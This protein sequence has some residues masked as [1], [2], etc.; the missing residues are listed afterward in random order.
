L[1]ACLVAMAAILVAVPP[2]AGAPRSRVQAAASAIL[3]IGSADVAQGAS[4]TVPLAAALDVYVLA[5]VTVDVQYD[6]GVVT[7]TACSADPEDLFDFSYCNVAYASDTVRFV[8]ISAQGVTGNPVLAEVSFLAVGEPGQ[9]SP[10]HLTADNFDD[11]SGTEV[12]VSMEDGQVRIASGGGLPAPSDLDASAISRSEIDLS[13]TDNSSDETA[14]RVERSPGGSADWTE[15]GSVGADVTEFED[16]GLA[17]GSG[18]DY[19]VR[20]YRA[21]DGQYSAYSNTDGDTTQPC[22]GDC[23]L[24]IG[25]ALIQEGESASVSLSAVLADNVLGAVTVEIDYDAEVVVATACTADPGGAFDMALCNVDDGPS[26][27]T[28]TALSTVGVSGSPVLA[29]ITFHAVGTAGQVS[30][31]LLTPTTFV[32]PDGNAIAVLVEDGTI[33]IWLPTEMRYVPLTLKALP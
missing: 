9:V 20:A 30:P 11:P 25:S 29:E 24:S 10:L 4:A 27:V 12:P 2:L 22:V 14:F 26:T 21:G 18:Y 3:A 32:D 5:A 28:L 23:I 7:A 33:T 31:L 1:G 17:C 19:R 16:T 13:W 8:A 6:P 15:V